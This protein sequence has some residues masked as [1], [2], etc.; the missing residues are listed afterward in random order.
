VILTCCFTGGAAIAGTRDDKPVSFSGQIAP[1]FKQRCAVCHITGQE[2]GLL[3]LVPARAYENIV[4]QASVQS[5]LTRVEPA[6]PA[7]SYLYL[8]LTGTHLEAGGEGLRMP[9]AAP[10]LTAAQLDLMRRWI[11]EGALHN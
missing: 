11:A 2:P 10:P 5:D 8:K 3:S 9:F 7:Q 4:G 6:D 1:L